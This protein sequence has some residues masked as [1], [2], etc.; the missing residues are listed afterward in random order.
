MATPN[1]NFSTLIAT[2]LQNFANKIVDNVITNTTLLYYLRKAGNIKVVSGGRTF[3]HQVFYTKNS[4]FAAR[5]SYDT[6]DLPVTDGITAA[7]Y[8]IKVVDGSIVLPTLD[9]A[10]NAGSR[11]KLL[12]YAEAKKMEAEVSMS[13]VLSD[14]IWASSPGT[15]DFDSIPLI[16]SDTSTSSTTIGGINQSDQSWW[17]NYVYATTV[18]TFN[19]TDLGLKMM[20]TC[21]N[22]STKGKMGPKLIVTTP[23]IYTLYQLAL[24]PNMRYQSS[25][26]EGRAGFRSLIYAGLPVVMDDD[27]TSAHMYFIDTDN[28]KFQVLAQGNMKMTSFQVARNQLVE[29]ALY[30]VFANLTCG[31]RRTNAV[32]L[33]ITG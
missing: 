10:M 2:T 23:S 13:E 1:S 5:G 27:C 8:S 24:T 6:I 7:E 14:Q 30:Y 20:D 22:N 31:S 9:V 3:V 28:L 18:G 33:S 15:N 12:D 32:A 25:E 26:D 21:L 29:S 16:I 17:R 11:E 4:S 19:S